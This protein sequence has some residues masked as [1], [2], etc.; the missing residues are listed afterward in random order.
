MSWLSYLLDWSNWTGPSGILVLLA[1]HL[2]YTGAALGAT[3][4]IGL[5][6]GIVLGHL[7]RGEA[8]VLGLVGI[9]RAV[10]AFGI[11]VLFAVSE[12]G[13]NLATLTITL[14][15]FALPQVLTN[16]Y[17][18]IA[19]ASAGAVEAAAG[20]GMTGWQIIRRIEIPLGLP[21]IA[22]GVRSAA[23]QIIAT[24]TIAAYAGAGG[25]GLLVFRGYDT[26][27]PKYQVAGAVL[28][29]VLALLA[30]ALLAKVQQMVT[31]V[32]LRKGHRRMA[33]SANV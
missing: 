5:P 7:H 2:E 1:Q 18:G 28:V 13:V 33:G 23:V 6:L 26:N 32:G 17:L 14:V 11:V 3:I 22:S 20:M 10:P 29:V 4:A 16:T 12:W 24:A 15:L 21:L 31:P 19:E 25:L 9:G 30:Q 27:M 8:L